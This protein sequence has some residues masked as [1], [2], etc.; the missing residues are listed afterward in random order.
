VVLL[1]FTQGI[2]AIPG[3]GQTI[4]VTGSAQV[5]IPTN[6][7]TISFSISSTATDAVSAQQQTS[8]VATQIITF[9]R[10]TPEVTKLSTT[11]I[12]I[13]PKYNFQDTINNPNGVI[14]G[15][16]SQNSLSFN[17]PVSQTGNLVDDVVNMGATSIDSVAFIANEHAQ[18]DAY[19]Q[20]VGLA[21]TDALSLAQT[22]L[23]PLN[24]CT[25]SSQILSIK[26]DSQNSGFITPFPLGFARRGSPNST[27]VVGGTTQ[28]SAN[29]VLS[30]GFVPCP[31]RR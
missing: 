10:N 6:I 13:N 21:T 17:V 25:S 18:T 2:L 23:S 7:T 4:T 24:L 27:P 1:F 19:N 3:S 11:F 14:T 9:L 26:V 12:S 16:T 20:A 22:T 30:A 5:T 29:V 8:T 28:I 15:Y 31:T